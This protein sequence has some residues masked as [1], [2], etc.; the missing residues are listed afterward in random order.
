[1]IKKK[2]EVKDLNLMRNNEEAKNLNLKKEIENMKNQ[3]QS[4]NEL[5]RQI[6]NLQKEL[7]QKNTQIDNSASMVQN[8]SDRVNNLQSQLQAKNQEIQNLEYKVSQKD[9][10]IQNLERRKNNTNNSHNY[11]I[12]SSYMNS[13]LV[14]TNGHT[15]EYTYYRSRLG[16]GYASGF[17]CNL[18]R[19]RGREGEGNYH[20]A[21]CHYDVCN[22][23]R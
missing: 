17:I 13:R 4:I 9:L 18:C 11:G 23:C 20:C 5:S 15:L 8:Y 1:M 22:N 21:F 10:E 2:K 7:R 16:N 3:T 6:I 12:F 14:C 19:G